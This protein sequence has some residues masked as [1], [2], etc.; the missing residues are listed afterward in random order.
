MC[1]PV[2]TFIRIKENTGKKREARVLHY[3]SSW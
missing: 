3:T 2:T 1:P